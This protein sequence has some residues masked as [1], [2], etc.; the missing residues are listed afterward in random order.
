[1]ALI[2]EDGSQVLN[3]DSYV[4]ST[5][6]EAFLTERGLLSSTLA[7]QSQRESMA[8][9]AMDHLNVL[10]YNGS[11]V[12]NTQ[13]LAFP[14]K[15]IM[16]SDN[17]ELAEDVIPEELKQAQMWL[18]YYIDAGSDPSTTQTQLV[19]SEQVDTL[20]IEYQ[21]GG[22]FKSSSINSLPNVKKLLKYLV[23]NTNYIDR[24]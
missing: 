4:N 19:K 3:S 2:V 7:T 8:L 11:R 5:T 1:M 10:E 23:S 15:G 21:D 17:R 18:I 12:S 14:R 24:A 13:S 16:L 22:S 20:K 6:I 9:R